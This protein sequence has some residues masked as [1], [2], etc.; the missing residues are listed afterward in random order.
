MR[1]SQLLHCFFFEENILKHSK[2]YLQVWYCF[3]RRHFL[4][5]TLQHQTNL[6]W[7]FSYS[8]TT[9]RKIFQRI[10]IYSFSMLTTKVMKGS[11]FSLSTNQINQFR[12][13]QI[14]S[15]FCFIFLRIFFDVASVDTET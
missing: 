5:W 13:L 8:T 9:C 7:H 3:F 12:M 11:V 6:Q 2:Y 10:I 15:S 4:H 14:L 1:N